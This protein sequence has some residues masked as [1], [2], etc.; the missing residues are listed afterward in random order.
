MKSQNIISIAALLGVAFSH[1]IFTQ[2]TAGGVT[3][4]N[5]DKAMGFC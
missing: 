3:N 4:G 5:C 2:L 1:T